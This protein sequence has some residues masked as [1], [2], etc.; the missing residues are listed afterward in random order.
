MMYKII[1]LS[2]MIWTSDGK[3]QPAF[4]VQPNMEI[5]QTNL[6]GYMDAASKLKEV[7]AL[8]GACT[9]YNGTPVRHHNLKES[10]PLDQD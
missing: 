3:V 6:V 4:V 8:A 10:T 2:L 7:V 1:L 5:C 9:E